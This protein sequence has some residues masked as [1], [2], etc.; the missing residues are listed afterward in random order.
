MAVAL[1]IVPLV[2][3]TGDI[4]T[5]IRG[6]GELSLSEMV[7][8]LLLVCLAAV[9]TAFWAATQRWKRRRV[10]AQHAM[11]AG[12]WEATLQENGWNLHPAAIA[13]PAFDPASL[14]ERASGT[15]P[16]SGPLRPWSD[17]RGFRRSRRA[18]VL[19]REDGFVALP[20]RALTEDQD[21]HLQRLLTRK[22]R[23]PSR[24]GS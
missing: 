19:L 24:K 20:L 12:E 21:G 15:A 3:A 8:P 6:E 18:L 14:T 5:N 13:E 2:G 17:L 7:L 10:I 4:Y 16:A 22:L 11:P 9:A 23:P 1:I